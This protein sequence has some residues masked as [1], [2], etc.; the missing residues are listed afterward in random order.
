MGQRCIIKTL[1]FEVAYP[2]LFKTAE[3]EWVQSW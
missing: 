3:E 2:N 1:L